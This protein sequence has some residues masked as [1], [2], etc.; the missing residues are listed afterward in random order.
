[1]TDTGFGW[2][3]FH[4][5]RFS[6]AGGPDEIEAAAPAT[7]AAWRAGPDAPF[8]SDGFR[9]GVSD[10]WGGV[11]FYAD[12]KAAEA[13]LALPDEALPFAGQAEEV[14]HGLLCV[15]AHRGELDLSTAQE[16]H[17]ALAPV[18][19]DPGGVMAVFTSAGYDTRDEARHDQIRD[20]L[21]KVE[22]VRA[23][24]GTLEANVV[25]MVVGPPDTVDGVTFSVW[26]SDA[27]MLAAA[28]KDGTHR[29]YMDQH[30]EDPMFDRSSFTRVRLLAS[31]GSWDGA[32]PRA[33]AA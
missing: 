18:A 33:V 1:M 2:L 23:F 3:T 14:W 7:A 25:H 31:R 11:G 12:R 13:A 10:I 5:A 27:G 26:R 30:K 22:E 19:S 32:D 24:Y 17:P 28:Y 6:R 16:P 9:T 15:I 20:F 29:K 8:G 4:R 21:R